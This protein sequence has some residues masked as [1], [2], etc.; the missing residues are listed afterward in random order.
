[1]P[2]RRYSRHSFA[3]GVKDAEGHLVLHGTEPYR[4]KAFADT[5]EHLV[6]DG[7]TLYTLAGAYYRKANIPRPSGLWWVIADFQPS[8]IH[9]PTL[10][11]DLGRILYIPSV[12]TLIEEIFAERRRR[13]VAR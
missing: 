3:Y 2:P 1:M 11:L 10:Q 5:R 12:R 6:R 7:D 13:L 9:D 4:F 8:P